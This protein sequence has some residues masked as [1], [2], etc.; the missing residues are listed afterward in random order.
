MRK[1]LML[2]AVLELPLF[3]ADPIAQR[4]KHTDLDKLTPAHSHG[5]TGFRVCQG[6]VTQADMELP[7]GFIN[8][9]RMEPGGGVA[10][11]FHNTVEEMFTVLDGT[12]ELTVDGRTS[13]VT[14]TVGAPCRLTHAHA[15][16]NP[17]DHKVDYMNINVPLARGHYDASNL[18]DSRDKVAYKDPIPQFITMRM[19]KALLRPEEHYRG[20]QGTVRY[21]R[22]LDPDVFLTNWAYMDHLLI[23]PGAS[24]GLHRHA[25]VE[26]IYYVMDGQGQVT[27]NNETAPIRKWDAIPIHL[28]E[29]HAFTNNSSADLELMIIGIAA[30]KGILDTELGGRG[31]RGGA[32]A[33]APA[34][35][36]GRG[37]N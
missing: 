29:A 5:S 13:V 19:D 30:R 28:N 3:A 12:A 17:T 22:V 27:L 33:P 15:I 35:R 26:E 9:C 11:H 8:R 31:R 1:S 24:E 36:G 6:L 18:E 37:G 23:P 25:G 32:T 34:G 21:R 20:G 4:I 10:E 14:G 2:L 16:Y 7:F